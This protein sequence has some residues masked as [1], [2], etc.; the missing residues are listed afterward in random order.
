MPEHPATFTA[1]LL[2]ILAWQ[3]RGRRLVLDPFAGTGGIHRVARLA[4]CQSVGV[5]LEHEWAAAHP[6]TVCADATRL[7]FGPDTFD[8]I[9]TSPAYGNRMADTYDGRDGSRR[10]TYRTA[11]GRPL[12]TGSGAALQWGDAYRDLHHA[13][14]VEMLRV[15]QPAGRL[16]VNVSDHVR[17]GKVVAVVDWWADLLDRLGCTLVERVDVP[18]P[19]LRHGANG[20]LRTDVEA[21]LVLETSR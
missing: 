21:V 18:T 7:P 15:L 10:H 19:R 5:E 9:C 12:T 4:G 20:D 14:A 3:L 6:R 8:A 17:R 11:L 2:P 16:I 1:E 13:A